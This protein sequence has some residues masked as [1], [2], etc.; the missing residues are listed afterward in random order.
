MNQ[1]QGILDIN[2]NVKQLMYYNKSIENKLKKNDK[3]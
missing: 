3:T 2:Y 1:S